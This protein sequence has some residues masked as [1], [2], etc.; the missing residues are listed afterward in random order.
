M[1][2]VLVT[3]SSGFVG[4]CLVRQ[5]IKLEKDVVAHSRSAQFTGCENTHSQI[6]SMT[7]WSTALSAVDVVIH[8]AARVHQMNE[9][10]EEAKT[11]YEE[12]NVAGTLNLAK[13]AA[14]AGV[15]RFVFISS[16]K[17]N[18]EWTKESVPFTADDS[19]HPLDAY[20]QSK[21][22]AEKEL[23]EFAQQ[24]GLELVIIRPPLVYG[25]GVKAN[26]LSM[27]NVVAKGLP[28]PLGM[29][30]SLRSF[31]YVENLVD[32]I[33]ECSEHP[34]AP[35][36]IFLVSDDEDIS[37]REL[38][39]LLA[40]LSGKKSYL[41][42]IPKFLL[43]FLLSLIGKKAAAQRLCQPLQLDIQKTKDILGWKPKYSLR[44]GLKKTVDSYLND[45]KVK[46]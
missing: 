2:K 20:G 9:S 4:Q 14:K 10:R 43:I 31:V 3:G 42:P 45:V 24:S 7:D 23:T 6:S 19:P 13:Q 39:R 37:I 35:G 34:K 12:V 17:V 46:L 44:E 22:E 30:K 11:L 33:L 1:N 32:L 25:P 27:M 40:Q 36:N 15:K 26:F 16:I 21:Y 29:I 8:C 38:L 28:L 18:G 5:L 41:L